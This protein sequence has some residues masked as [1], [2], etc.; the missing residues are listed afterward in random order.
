MAAA[1]ALDVASAGES[2][3]IASIDQ[4][5]SLTDVLD[6][7]PGRGVRTVTD[8][9]DALEIDSLALLE[10]HFSVMS[11][12]A[13]MATGHEH[14]DR[15]AL[16]SPEELTGFPG[17]QELLALSEVARLADSGRW[18]TI[19]VDAPASADAV[20]MLAAPRTFSDYMERIWPQHSR[21]EAAS[22]PDPRPAVV[23]ALFDRVLSGIAATRD[24]L[25][26]PA[27]TTVVLVA[28]PDRAGYAEMR[29]MRS[30][31]AVVGL[32]LEAVIVNGIVPAFDDD[33][34][35]ARWLAVRR[36]EQMSVLD[37]ITAAVT[38]VPV[39]ECPRTAGEPV[40]LVPL[41][42]MAAALRRGGHD[43]RALGGNSVDRVR[44]QHESGT[45]VDA[46]YAMRLHLPLA[47]PASL[48]LGRVDDDLLVGVDGIRHRLR[49]AS[50]LRRC[51]VS[52]A[53]FDGTDLL[54]R[55]VPDPAV[56]PQ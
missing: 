6:L 5:H 7:V 54:V 41:G 38:E 3:L 34:A 11:S 9:L 10:R 55:F 40:G 47:D 16:P 12:L 8:G 30:W 13:S 2:V 44:V 24:L 14:G 29:R 27:R 43:L 1:T 46:V 33:G 20:R 50:G 4:A 15:F 26:D 37:D 19:V 28:T 56:W 18:S 31:I 22:G 52:E 49:L 48:T 35:A 17:V 42:E 32:C 45:G 36:A 23:V 53:E 25:D 51:T 21:V 39:I